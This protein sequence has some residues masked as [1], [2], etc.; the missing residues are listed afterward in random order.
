[1]NK[2]L[3]LSFVVGGFMFAGIQG[4]ADNPS[5]QSNVEEES[6]VAVSDDNLKADAGRRRGKGHRGRRKGGNGL[7]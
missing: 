6:W 1:M 2:L 5:G 4:E 7:R 3:I